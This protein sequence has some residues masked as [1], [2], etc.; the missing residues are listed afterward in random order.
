MSGQKNKIYAKLDEDALNLRVDYDFV[1]DYVDVFKL[2]EYLGIKLIPYSTITEKQWAVIADIDIKDG[3]T[4]IRK[5]NG[6]R[7]YYTYYNDDLPYRRQRFTIAHE[8]KHVVYGEEEFDE[9]DEAFADHFA[10]ALLAPSCLVMF[11]IQNHNILEI[12][13]L[14]DISESAAENAV[15]A[16]KNRIKA[17]GMELNQY[18][19]DY[20][21]CRNL[22]KIV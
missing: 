22:H 9:E 6:E 18:E 10:R 5:S 15:K 20:I 19:I 2:A 16:A 1:S 12:S 4:V 7:K 17:K 3:F 11:M 13:D 21:D 8:I 14:F